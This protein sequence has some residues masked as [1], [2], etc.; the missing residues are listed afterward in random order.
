MPFGS[1][2]TSPQ[3]AV[4]NAV[5]LMK[6]GFMDAVKLEGTA[7]SVLHYAVLYGCCRR[8][9][10]MLSSWKVLLHMYYAVLC[11]AVLYG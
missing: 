10:C 2:E 6:E 11:H 1:Y 4:Q 3:A 8:E 5:R 9:T 7:L